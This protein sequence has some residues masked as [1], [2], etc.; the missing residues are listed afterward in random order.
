M[1]F[2]KKASN[3]NVF[4]TLLIIGVT[5][6]ISVFFNGFVGD[7]KEQIYNYGLVNNFIDLPKVFFYHHEVLEHNGSI[8]SGY[9]KPLMLL[10][11]YTTRIFFGIHPFFYHTP[12]IILGIINSFLVYIFL[13]K[14]LKQEIAFFGTLIFL[15]H[16]INQETM[17]YVSNIQEILFFVFGMSALILISNAKS[18]KQIVVSGL[19]L[20]CSL[21]SK[22]TGILF[23]LISVM[24]VI[25]FKKTDY[26][27]YLIVFLS[28]IVVYFFFRIMSQG[29][30]VFWIEPSPMS[31][32]PAI[33]RLQHA[34]LLFFYYIKTFFYPNIL[35]FNQQWI[36][37]EFQIQNVIFP[38]IGSVIFISSI[39]C[40]NFLLFF[41]KSKSFILFLFFSIWFF[42]GILPH[43]QIIALDATVADRWFYFSSVGLIGIGGIG[44]QYIYTKYKKR[45]T[46]IFTIVI[47]ACLIL[48]TRTFT[49]NMEWKDAFTLYSNDTYRAQSA[50]MENNLGDEYFKMGDLKNAE[51]HFRNALTINPN[52]WIAYNNLGVIEEDKKNYTKALV[53]YRKAFAKNKRLPVYENIA[54]VLVLSKKYKEAI[55][56]IKPALKIYPFS[57]TLF[58]TLSLAYYEQENLTEALLYAKKSYE[59]FPDYKSQNVITTIENQMN[60]KRD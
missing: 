59:I 43:M 3:A 27:K 37:K 11:F 10:Y 14:F 50:L 42:I 31:Q 54:R 5:V 33:K 19:L 55:E 36:L 29:T 39:L 16:P 48:S 15:I 21:L 45:Q 46:L 2:L 12:Q 6:Y 4:L 18:T 9:Y 44:L 25:L 24:Y 53:Y 26:K 22:E 41:K 47:A 51:I 17:A 1:E 52:L 13:K 58:L 28:T 35:T 34:P 7:D 56:F 49:R 8:L 32:I 23:F 57:A 40:A 38:L 30:S 60:L 20:L